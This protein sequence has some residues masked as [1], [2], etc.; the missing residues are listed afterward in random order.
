MSWVYTDIVKDHFMNPR[1]VLDDSE[2]FE[3]DAQGQVGDPKCGDEMLFFIKVDKESETITACKW[4]TYGCASAIASAS[5]LSVMATG[6]KLSEAF[7]I[8]PKDVVKKLGQ[9]PDR[10]IHCSVLG[11]KALRAAIN[12][13]YRN[14]GMNEKVREEKRE[15][16]CHCLDIYDTEIEEEV[17]EG[18]RDFETLQKRTKIGTVCGEC[19]EK[20]T[21][22]IDFYCKKHFG[23]K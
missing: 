6:M 22:L 1:N 2:N 13:Y 15:I 10:K 8:T 11:D 21:E 4:K 20:A 9:L 17:L 12:N 14:I 7:K 23:N 16:V 5:M 3:F 19:I 18:V